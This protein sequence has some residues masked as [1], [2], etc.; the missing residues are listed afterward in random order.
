MN[1]FAEPLMP[2]RTLSL[3]SGSGR[4]GS[5][6]SC[7]YPLSVQVHQLELILTISLLQGTPAANVSKED[8]L[9]ALEVRR[10]LL[11]SFKYRKSICQIIFRLYDEDGNGVVTE[12]EIRQIS[13]I[14][15]VP[16]SVPQYSH[17]VLQEPDFRTKFD[18]GV[19]LVLDEVDAAD[20][21]K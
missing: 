10:R 17:T 11:Q 9:L 6:S 16:R 20:K 14:I 2:T 18:D 4:S 7:S 19:L 13:S 3:R 5:T 1:V 12:K 21:E 15:Q 8:F